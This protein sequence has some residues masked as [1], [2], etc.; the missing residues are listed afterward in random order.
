MRDEKT[1]LTVIEKAP[2]KEAQKPVQKMFQTNPI[3]KRLLEFNKEKTEK[4]SV[5]DLFKR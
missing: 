5:R 2:E 1:R 3:V 4:F